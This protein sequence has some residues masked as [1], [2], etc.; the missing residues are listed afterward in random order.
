MSGKTYIEIRGRDEV[1]C[2][3]SAEMDL[4]TDELVI[5]KTLSGKVHIN[6]SR[7]RLCYMSD[8]RIVIVGEIEGI[9]YE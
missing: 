2:Q 1:F 3:G 8:D 5:L 7:L 6:G 4:Y 9:R